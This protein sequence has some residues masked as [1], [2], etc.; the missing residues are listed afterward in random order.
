METANP[1][2]ELS[3]EEIHIEAIEGF[4]L[5]GTRYSASFELS[6]HDE[7]YFRSYLLEIDFGETLTFTIR[8]QIEK[9]FMSHASLAVDRHLALQIGGRMHDLTPEGD[10]ITNLPEGVLRRLYHIDGGPQYVVGD[11]G[12]CYMREGAAWELVPPINEL[13]LS[14]IHGPAP[15]LIHACGNG[16]TLLRL[17]GRAWERVELPD[18]RSFTT[19]EVAN[20]RLIHIGGADGLALALRDG[21]LIELAAPERDFFSIRSFK[22][23]RYWSDANWGLNIQDGDSVVPFRELRHAFV[24]HTSPEKLVIAGWKEIFIFD[25]SEWS[26]F[27]F[28]YDGNIFLSRLDMSQYGG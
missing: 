24:M 18:Q 14:D 28:G 23:H 12:V 17:R 16:G 1:I 11:E 26:G 2:D 6:D 21:E 10:S 22:G 9:T 15:D 25:G 27:Q 13:A 4:H 7:E 8:K 20:E 3:P 5:G 19:L